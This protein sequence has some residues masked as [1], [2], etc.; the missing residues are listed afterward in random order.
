MISKTSGIVFKTIKYSDNSLIVRVYTEAFGLRTYMIRGMNSKKS[1]ARKGAFQ[2]LSILDLLV[3]EKEKGGIQSIREVESV[4]PYRSIP[5]NI[6]K[7]CIS[8]FINE[9]MFSTISS[10]I[11]DPALYHFLHDSLISLDETETHFENLHLQFLTGLTHYLGIAPRDNY[12][13]VNQFFDLQE[14]VFVS[15]PPLHVNWLDKALSRKL[16]QMTTQP[17]D[18][19]DLFTNSAARNEFMIRMIDYYRLHIPGFGEMKSPAV[20]KEVL[21]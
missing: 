11:A 10:E 7:G 20:L 9:V 8:L 14:G 21:T 16:F 13:P 6:R 1:S 19:G 5:F 17:G 2:P 3:Y 4:Y 15:Q 12:S 18:A